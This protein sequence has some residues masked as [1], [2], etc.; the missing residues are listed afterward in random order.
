[1]NKESLAGKAVNLTRNRSLK[2]VLAGGA[3]VAGGVGI[4]DVMRPFTPLLDSPNKIENQ[5][6]TSFPGF[7]LQKYQNDQKTVMNFNF[8][9]INTIKKGT[10]QLQAPQKVRSAVNYTTSF[11]NANAL[12]DNRVKQEQKKGALEGIAGIVLLALGTK[13]LRRQLDLWEKEQKRK[14]FLKARQNTS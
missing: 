5:V 3:F 9:N 6:V 8:E 12:Y 11:E 13:L 14:K 7:S 4:I 10:T 2:I 1:M